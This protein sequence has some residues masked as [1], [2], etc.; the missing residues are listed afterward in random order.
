MTTAERY[1][2]ATISG[3]L[4]GG[5]LDYLHAAGMSPSW[6]TRLFRLK[7]ANDAA[8]YQSVLHDF[9]KLATSTA[10]RLDWGN[11]S[12][13]RFMT[14]RVLDFWLLDTCRE[15]SGRGVLIPGKHWGSTGEAPCKHPA[16]TA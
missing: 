13:V 15:C 9:K 3:N 16:T 10:R 2:I 6:G 8:Q 14:K 11:L 12:Q 4:S 7:F 1:S 5:S